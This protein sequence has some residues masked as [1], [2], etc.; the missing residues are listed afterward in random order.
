MGL[1]EGRRD[2]LIPLLAQAILQSKTAAGSHSADTLPLAV[3]FSHR[4]PI[5]VAEEAKRFAERHAPEVGVGVI[6]AQ[7]LRMFTGHGLERFDAVPPRRATTTIVSRPKLPHL[8]SDL[9]Q[10]MLKILL[11]QVLPESLVNVPRVGFRNASQLA[12]A[13]DV[14]TMSASRFVHRLRDEGFLDA[15]GDALMLVRVDELLERWVSANRQA[16]REVPVR[17]ILKRSD[18]QLDVSLANHIHEDKVPARRSRGVGGAAARAKI[19]C[20]LGLFAAADKLGLGF[21]SGV[22]IYLYL[23][24]IETDVLKGFG[25]TANESG[26]PPDLYV[27]VPASREAVFRAAPIVDGVPVS[28]VLQVWL[29]VSTHP[30]RGKEQADVIRKRA[31]G[32]LL[33]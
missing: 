26:T 4:I 2:R 14:A 25:L 11:G 9:N 31:L 27:R 13:A 20:C 12:A 3:V 10:W 23:E 19:R 29:D 1:S 6:D 15:E 24:R 33:S 7:G 17:W 32:P 8:F 21:V 16:F 28:D 5:S 18:E 22:P 30:A